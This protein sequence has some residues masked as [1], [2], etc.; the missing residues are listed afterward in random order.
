[1]Q[2]VDFETELERDM[3]FEW[4]LDR[5]WYQKSFEIGL[6]LHSETRFDVTPFPEPFLGA[7]E[8]A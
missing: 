4:I 7:L 8:G 2:K 1:M 3:N 5:F 6:K